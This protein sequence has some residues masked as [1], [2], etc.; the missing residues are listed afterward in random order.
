MERGVVGDGRGVAVAIVEAG[1]ICP[2]RLAIVAGGSG[3]GLDQRRRC[4][5]RAVPRRLWRRGLPSVWPDVV[6]R[7]GNDNG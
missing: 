2:H 6:A 5:A 4:H 3:E 7:D 1:S